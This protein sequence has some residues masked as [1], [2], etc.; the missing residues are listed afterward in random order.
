MPDTRLINPWLAL[1]RGLWLSAA[2]IAMGLFIAGLPLRAADI[3]RAYQGNLPIYLTQN[4]KGE[5]VISLLPD[6]EAS[7]AGLQE[8][9]IL[10]AV[11]NK[12][13]T[14]L[15]QARAWLVGDIGTPVT[16]KIRTGDFPSRQV[17]LTRSST[18]GQ[19]LLHYG[20]TSQFSVVFTWISEIGFTLLCLGIALV[21][22][23][24]RSD[25]GMALLS[26]LIITMILIGLSLPV[27]S[28]GN[29]ASPVSGRPLMDAWYALAFGLMILFFYLFPG[30]RFVSQVTRILAV[31]L[32]L[33]S[34]LEFVNPSWY[35]WYQTNQIYA[36]VTMTWLITGFVA[37]IYR[38]RFHA[39]DAQRQ[40]IRWIVWGAIAS[41][42]GL[43]LQ[44]VLPNFL[45]NP[46]MRV[47]NDFIFYPLGQLLKLMLPV[48]ISFAILRYRLWHIDLVINR[49]LVYG[50]LSALTMLGYLLTIFVLQAVFTGLSN[51]A[52]SF[53]ATGLI[54]ILF[55]PLR[56]RLQRAVNRWMY[57]ER[58]DPYAVLARLAGML[59]AIPVV[60]EI[61]PAITRTIG[62]AL[63]IPYV[64]IML[65]QQGHERLAASY[66]KEKAHLLTLPLVYQGE[67]V[68]TLQLAQR[69]ENESFSIADR[70]L[71]ENIAHQ[72]GA[73]AQTVRLNTELLRSRTQIVTEREEERLRIR[74][75]LHDELGPILASQGLKLAAVRQLVRA[76]PEKAEALIDEL[77]QQSQQTVADIRRLVHGLRPPALD[78][79]GLVESIRDLVRNHPGDASVSVL[80]FEVSALTEPLPKF[81]AAVEANAY[82]I[83]LEA[84][85]NAVRHAQARCC[86]IRFEASPEAL[87][88]HIQ[89]DGVGIPA[90]YRSGVG[91]ESMRARAEEI[92]GQ[93]RI[94][95][96]QPHG[97]H[98]TVWLPLAG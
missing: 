91:L 4:Q 50:S 5:I 52:T 85:N 8:G 25:D 90:A 22:F 15:E 12:P 63:K 94:E 48:S 29:Y 39:T 9:D 96:V 59:G 98:L 55:E 1:A 2:L 17:S 92:G 57:G 73:T 86:A 76:R 54:A 62:Q 97:T 89:D 66:G 72:A 80:K 75:D 65:S 88:I 19:I 14:H 45:P 61:L 40:Q 10:V 71:I 49:V 30:G 58:D 56:Q 37:L 36:L 7:Q 77:V 11:G 64:A 81:P 6:S 79:L 46:G 47:L 13:V 44:I 16:L 42:L 82:R 23:W 24:H 26:S 53:L 78:Q 93:L 27:I 70:R 84:V 34:V 38:Y 68:G 32:G 43:F 60:D 35:P 67:T 3:E 28:F 95:Q 87:V 83:V 41:T 18:P 21:I 74:R 69:S 51:P 31:V 20:L 33:W